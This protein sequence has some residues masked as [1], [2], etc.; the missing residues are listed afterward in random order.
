MSVNSKLDNTS[1]FIP[2]SQLASIWDPRV[3]LRNVKSTGNA[4]KFA[5]R[6]HTGMEQHLQNNRITL[7]GSMHGMWEV[8]GGHTPIKISQTEIPDNDFD[9]SVFG[10]GT[11]WDFLY[12]LWYDTKYDVIVNE[13]KVNILNCLA[14]VHVIAVK[15]SDTVGFRGEKIITIGSKLKGTFK[16]WRN[17]Y[18]VLKSFEMQGVIQSKNWTYILQHIALPYAS[19]IRLNKLSIFDI[20]T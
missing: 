4:T 11:L 17:S 15:E 1:L 7:I 13:T 8:R 12:A 5:F 3:C 14:C 20:Y 9:S 19:K 6:S 16:I 2:Y 18:K 10:P